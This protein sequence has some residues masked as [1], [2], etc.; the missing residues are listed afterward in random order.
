[1][2]IYYNESIYWL[3]KSS[4]GE[5]RTPDVTSVVMNDTLLQMNSLTRRK[6]T[7]VLPT[8]WTKPSQNY[9]ASN[10]Y[11]R[12]FLLFLW[13]TSRVYS[14]VYIYLLSISC[15]ACLPDWTDWQQHQEKFDHLFCTERHLWDALV[16]K[17]FFS[18]HLTRNFSTNIFVFRNVHYFIVFNENY[19]NFNLNWRSFRIPSL[20][21]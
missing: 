2:I 7:K 11:D 20:Y 14:R 9:Q 8:R 5:I 21:Y 12:Y 4:I 6:N 19:R 16:T 15:H 10:F 3:R 17:G 13:A 18:D 1:M